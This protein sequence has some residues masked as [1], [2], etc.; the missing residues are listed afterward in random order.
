MERQ[1]V[2]SQVEDVVED[3]IFLRH[4]KKR[5]VWKHVDSTWM[6]S[7]KEILAFRRALL[8]PLTCQ[9]FQRF[10]SLKGDFLENGVL[11]WLE[12][13][14]YKDLFHSH[15][16]E[17]TVQHKVTLIIRSFIDSPLPPG[18][19]I[20]IPPEQARDILERRREMGPYVF[21]EAQMTV[22]TQLFKLW[23]QFLSFRSSVEEERV[24]PE[25]E[26]RK[27]KQ[28]QKL[29]RRRREEEEARRAQ[30]EA[31]KQKSSF[32][33]GLFEDGCSVFG[34][35]QEGGEIGGESGAPTHPAQQVSWSYS[36]YISAL[37]Q[38]EALLQTHLE[39]G[40][41]TLSVSSGTVSSRRSVRSEGRGSTCSQ[42]RIPSSRAQSVQQ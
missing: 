10:V 2:K 20:N 13:Q 12:V 5:E 3:Q 30:E 4:R 33:E 22:F 9:Q 32:A 35:S 15:C 17:A 14:R 37:E 40:V 39:R 29:H 31:E 42:R 41:A 38:E 25:L 7:S 1:K 11:F 27:E 8:N 16:D 36:R 21:R 6:A 23:P 34:G 24:L 18:L 26:V 28:R 19:Q